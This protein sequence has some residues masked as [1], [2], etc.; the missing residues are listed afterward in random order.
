MKIFF[1][2]KDANWQHY[3]N[4]VLSYLA[5]KNNATVKILTT[6]ELKPHLKDNEVLK[7]KIFNNWFSNAGKL[8]FFPSAI[9]Y[10]LK[11]R[12]DC[13]LALNNSTNLTEYLCVILC[14]LMGIRFVWWTHGYDHK[15]NKSSFKQGLKNSYTSLFLKFANA[16]I[17]FSESG[18]AYLVKKGIGVKKIFVAPNTLDTDKLAGVK[19]RLESVFNRT[20]F[21]HEKFP[22]VPTDSRFIL[23]S[24]R[25][26]HYK[27]VHNLIECLALTSKDR[28]DIH[29]V[30][31]GDGAKSAEVKGLTKELGLESNVHFLGSIF[32]DEEVAKYF[33]LSDLFIIPGLVGLAIVH[34]FSYGKPLITEDISYHSPEIQYLIDGENGYF[35]PEDDVQKM[36]DLILKSL[37]NEAELQRLS[38]N[39]LM[40]VQ[41]SASIKNMTD[42]MYLALSGGDV[43]K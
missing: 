29:I 42:S 6:G 12:P 23:F 40:T 4:E 37:A 20:E 30:I 13:V 14:R 5:R 32:D 22:N 18:K 8:N 17:V 28:N 11:N 38:K 2:S 36:A 15:P 43:K 31:I 33:L 24:G 26:N 25:I 9:W 19:N 34:A 16:V 7:Y 27:K 35:V 39:A 1:L 3:R 10:I 21:I 41:K